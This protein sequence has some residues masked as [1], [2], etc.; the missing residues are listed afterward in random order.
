MINA[1]S[2]KSFMRLLLAVCILLPARLQAQ[3]MVTAPMSSTPA[4]GEYY[5]Y[6][7]ITLSPGFWFTATAGQSLHLYILNSDCQ[8]LGTTPTATQNYILTSVPRR[9]GFN[10]LATGL[11]TCDVMQSVQY[12]DGL[13]RPLQTVQVKGSPLGEDI[14]QP[15]AY[16]AFGREAVKYLPYTSTG[17]DGSYKATAISDQLSFY[18]PPGTAYTANQLPAGVAH[19]PSPFAATAFEA[20]PLNRVSEQGAPGDPWQLTGMTN[21][22]GVTA[23]HTLKMKYTT[24][25]LTALPDTSSYVAALYIISAIDA[26]QNRTLAK[27]IVTNLNYPAGQLYVTVSKDENW[28]GGKPGTTEEYK[29]LEGRVVLK[30]TFNIQSG[31]LEVLSTYYVYDDLGNLAYVLPPLSLADNALPDQ[32]KLN[33]YCY[34][35]RYDERNRLTQKRLPGKDWEY[36][37]YNTLDQVVATQDA[38]QRAKSPQEWTV[39]RYDGLGRVVVTGIYAYGSP[40]GTDNR[41]AV[42]TQANGF[43]TLWETPTGTTVNFGYTAASFPAS[44]TTTLSVNYYDDYTFSGSNPYPFA[45]GTNM[46][47]GLATGSLTGV[48]G[49]TNMLLRV[50]YYDDKGRNIKTY[51]QHY[52]GGTVSAY[53]YDEVTSSY[54]FTDQDSLS[55]RNH[56]TK[57]AANTA[58][59]G[60]TIT[61]QYFYDHMGRKTKSLE[62]INSGANVLLAQNEYNEIG[63]LKTKHLHGATGQAPFLQDIDYAYNERGWLSKINDPATAPTV[64]KLFSEGLSYNVPKYGAVAQFNGNIAEQA[65]QVYISPKPGLQTAT[66]SYDQINRLIAGTGS[67]G[68]SETGISYDLMGNILALTRATAPNAGSLAYSYTGNQL[69]SVTKSG[70]AFRSYGYDLNGNALSDGVGNAITYNLFNLPESIPTRTLTYTYDATGNKLRKVS[71]GVTTEYIS[72]IQYTGTTIDFIQTEEG[73]A[74]NS[75]GAYTYE[76]TLTDHLGNNRVTFDPTHGKV[77]E[78]D[79]YPFGLNVPRVVVSP[80]NEYLYNKKELQEELT[81]YDYGARFYDPIIAR[82]TSADPLAE[83]DVHLSPYNYGRNNPIRNIDPDGMST[84][85]WM[86]EHGLTNDDLITLYETPQQNNDGVSTTED[87][88]ATPAINGN[89]GGDG[90]KDKGKNKNNNKDNKND[91]KNANQGEGGSYTS[92]ALGASAV[93]VADDIT[94]IGAIDDVAIPVII[95]GA[96]VRDLTQIKYITYTLK[97]ANGKTY[98]G[99]S[100]GYGDPYSIMM[101]R[102]YSHHMRA[103]GFGNP[104]LDRVAQG[105][106]LGYYAIRGREQ[107]AVN[108]YG[109]IGSSQLGNGINPIWQYNPNR[110]L[111]MGASSLMFGPYVK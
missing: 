38:V 56:Y 49:T 79:Y 2:K 63:Q 45:A 90:G 82:W 33:A 59:L 95:A 105:Y 97:N 83:V 13:G 24:N 25:N 110:P 80:K 54:N 6:G 20:S 28:T 100:S 22:S 70:A 47:K 7:S 18:H 40:I 64:T 103:L 4:A 55:V 111:Y 23:G 19:I 76:Y 71:S 57:N 26:A 39:A 65:Y 94:G 11:S 81:Q 52:L 27:G 29:D 35:Y 51:K 44:L 42:Q 68:L 93:L 66:Y 107:D 89:V 53:N 87:S 109:G 14:V 73:R 46:T 77:D 75:A 101:N 104:Q 88:P 96:A 41:A 86:Q 10:P 92:K 69:N 102:F 36:L 17:V 34:Q 91:Q 3:T 8:A 48:L 30:R 60:V 31:S 43:T 9:A 15:I 108:A 99:R 106:P 62:Q 16:D 21:A 85:S 32:T 50:N 72:G 12:S 5:G 74:L 84:E 37:V 1:F 67:T 78:N 98:V 58:V 61:N